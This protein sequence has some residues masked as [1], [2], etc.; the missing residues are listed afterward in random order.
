[1]LARAIPIGSWWRPK[2]RPDLFLWR[3]LCFAGALAMPVAMVRAQPIL[4]KTEYFSIPGWAEGQNGEAL[5][6]FRRSCAEMIG[7]GR[8]FLRPVS[9]GG[10]REDW[11]GVCVRAA[12]ASDARAFFETNFTPLRV[13]DP[14]RPEGL[15]TGY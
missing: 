3:L 2:R 12:A 4:E 15:F 10:S 6:A 8:A 9:F 14:V 13:H 1:M 11:L 5:T 7:E